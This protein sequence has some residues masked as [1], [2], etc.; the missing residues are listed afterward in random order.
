MK[1]YLIP[2]IGIL[3]LSCFSACE[4]YSYVY[5]VNAADVDAITANKNKLKTTSQ[6]V[7]V[8]YVNLFQKPLS[9][10]QLY[11]ISRVILSIGD[12]ELAHE[13]LISNFMNEPDVILPSNESM[14]ADIPLFL[15]D[16][17]ERFLIRAPSEAEK[18]FFIRYIEARP[19]VTPEMVYFAFALS[20]E[21]QFY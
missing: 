17:Y 1:K 3:L 14:R 11:D 12:K 4:E 8:M 19:D 18:E 15:D 6:Y 21:Y 20:N 13:I 9:A 7:A 10:N 5:E 16:V 2:I